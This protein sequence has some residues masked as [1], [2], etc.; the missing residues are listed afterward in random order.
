M[1]LTFLTTTYNRSYKLKELYKSLTNQTC[2]DFTWLI[3]DDGSQDNTKDA[4]NN[5]M[6]KE[7]KFKIEY[8]YKKNGGKHKAL[9]LGISKIKTELFCVIDD[10][11][12]IVCDAVENILNIHLLTK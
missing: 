8:I 10:D 5:I 9:N 2:F 4:V 6:K 12:F 1:K 11:E 7:N 3:I